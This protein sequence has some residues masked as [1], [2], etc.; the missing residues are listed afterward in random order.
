MDQTTAQLGALADLSARLG[1]ADLPFWLRGGWALDFLLGRVS[2]E[3]DDL[4]VVA[5][6]RD[7]DALRAL[8]EGAGWSFGRA[9]GAQMDFTRDGLDLSVLFVAQDERGQVTAPGIPEWTWVPGALDGETR[10][11]VGVSCRVVSPAQLLDEKEGYAGAT[12][13]PLRPKD[14]LSMALLRELLGA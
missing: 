10:T 12:G 5:W 14:H 2:R 1:S 4:D 3:H 8:L 7:A 9:V 13:R 6:R 11:L